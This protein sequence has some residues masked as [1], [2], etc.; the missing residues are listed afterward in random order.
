[1][2]TATKAKADATVKEFTEADLKPEVVELAGK[3]GKEI[4]LSNDGVATV[5]DD[6][7]VRNMPE[8]VTEE[9]VRAHQKYDTQFVAASALAFGEAANKVAK[10]H[11]DLA[12]SSLTVKTVGRDNI[13]VNWQRENTR[14]NPQVKGE[15]ITTFGRTTVA[16]NQFADR[17]SSGDLSKVR[18]IIANRAKES[19]GK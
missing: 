15:T 8:G 3:I 17:G 18:K 10:K 13:E 16:I 7:Y 5:P 14:P 6:L 2:T 19:F 9:S 11:K 4:T 1:M 12:E